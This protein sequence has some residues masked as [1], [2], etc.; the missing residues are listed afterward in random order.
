[1]LELSNI[2]L[3]EHSTRVKHKTIF[4]HLGLLLGKVVGYDEHS[5]H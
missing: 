2:Y 4:F 3:N 5:N 1:M